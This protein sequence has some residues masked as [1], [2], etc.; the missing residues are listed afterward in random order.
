[1]CNNGGTE[2]LPDSVLMFGA[3]VVEP[4]RGG[5]AQLSG[6]RREPVV[7]GDVQESKAGGPK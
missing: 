1:M 6:F 5:E 2:G 3:P 4:S 7:L